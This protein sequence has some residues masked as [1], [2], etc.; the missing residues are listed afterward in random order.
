MC[1]GAFIVIRARLLT[2]NKF[3]NT[4]ESASTGNQF[5]KTYFLGST[6]IIVKFL[7]YIIADYEEH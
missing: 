7:I 4:R 3:S 6:E 2:T 1:P 5:L